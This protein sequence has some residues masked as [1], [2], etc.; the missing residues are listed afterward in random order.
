[1]RIKSA[2]LSCVSVAAM[3]GAAVADDQ[4]ET[5]YVTA[6][7][8]VAQSLIAAPM[9]VQVIS[10]IE[11]K[12]KRINDIHDLVT[13]AIPG[14][15][16]EE[17]IGVFIRDYALRGS[18]AGGGVGD[19]MIGYYIDDTAW[20]IPNSQVAPSLRIVDIDRVEVLRGPYGTLYGAGAMGGTMIF[21]TKNPDL[22]KMTVNAD[23]TFAGMQNADNLDYTVEG[24]ISV[25]L[26]DGKLGLRVSGGYNY[27]P[28][29]ASVYATDTSAPPVARHANDVH[30]E[31]I[32][33]VLL[34]KPTED[35]TARFQYWAFGGYQ[36][37]STQVQS[38]SPA[39]LTNWGNIKGFENSHSHLYSASLQYDLDGI[40]LTSAT[41]YFRTGGESLYALFP[42]IALDQGGANQHGRYPGTYSFQEELRA[43]S[44]TPGPL[45]W[46]AGLYY[47]DGR[48]LYWYSIPAFNIGAATNVKTKNWSTFGEVSYDLFGG[49]LVPL[50][51]LRY[52]NDDRSFNSITNPDSATPT[53]ASGSAK[54][55]VTTWR[56]NLSWHPSDDMTVYVNAG[57]GFRSP[58]MQSAPQVTA[59]NKDGINGQLTLKPDTDISYEVGL[60]GRLSSFNIDYSVSGY[61]LAYKNFQTGVNT[62]TGI[63]AFANLGTARTEGIDLELHWFP[64][65]GLSLGFLGNINRSVYGTVDPSVA[66]LSSS[67]FNVRKGGQMLNTPGYTARFDAGYEWAIGNDYTAYVIAAAIPT[68]K[69]INQYGVYSAAYTLY[70]TSLGVRFGKY[71]VELFGENLADARGPFYIRAVGSPK[72]MQVGPNPRT[73]GIRASLNFE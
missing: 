27:Q 21:H 49:K 53:T 60:K 16:E 26:V 66:A 13:T 19:P 48:S 41:S 15:S 52:F 29:Y 5:V 7:K 61:W 10:D 59:L 50:V 28:G 2:I 56:A 64:L 40:S 43:S 62:S 34:Y 20:A 73:I 22:H 42:T 57:N 24:A 47:Q 32:R 4:L 51:G 17:Q 46:V 58:I 25:P 31:D 14:A 68:A 55:S 8:G 6:T 30:Q 1:M 36:N 38:V 65:E 11:L 63:S 12:A 35:F 9:A 33:A 54:P 18:G 67:G 3:A 23:A 72:N 37:Y 70:N 69:R 44:T 71:N 45:H 39:A